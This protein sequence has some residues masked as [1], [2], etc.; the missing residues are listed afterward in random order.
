MGT[1]SSRPRS[2][3]DGSD[4]SDKS[5]ASSSLPQTP[6]CA[7]AWH[8]SYIKGLLV[9]QFSC[10]IPS[11][12]AAFSPELKE[13]PA[14]VGQALNKSFSILVFLVVLMARPTSPHKKLE[15]FSTAC[16]F[17]GVVLDTVFSVRNQ[18]ATDIDRQRD[19]ERYF[20]DNEDS[21]A[22]LPFPKKECTGF[23]ETWDLDPSSAR[24]DP[25]CSC[26]GTPALLDQFSCP[27]DTHAKNASLHNDVL[28]YVGTAATLVVLIKITRHLFNRRFKAQTFFTAPD[29]EK[30]VTNTIPIL[31]LSAFMSWG[32]LF[33]ENVGCLLRRKQDNVECWNVVSSNNAFFDLF[34]LLFY[35]QTYVIPF[36]GLATV[37]PRS[38][39]V[40]LVQF[41]FVFNLQMQIL[42]T[43]VVGFCALFLFATRD[44]YPEDHETD[45]KTGNWNALQPLPR[46]S[47]ANLTMLQFTSYLSYVVYGLSLFVVAMSFFRP[48]DAEVNSKIG[49]VQVSS[50]NVRRAIL[51]KTQ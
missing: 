8:H 38:F 5:D 27:R 21:Q 13:T 31:L 25:N 4:A 49:R 9:L 15:Y 43:F 36:Q 42:G 34:L 2:S 1:R 47:E 16:L 19:A 51:C 30:Y 40:N 24:L 32:F 22:S 10:L 3:S 45:K 26:I 11:V 46:P 29:L 28:Q 20:F 6:Q 41:D 44:E 18:I 12:V 7:A 35:L 33:S 17:A 39:I 23:N 50:A 14:Q 48:V 37:T